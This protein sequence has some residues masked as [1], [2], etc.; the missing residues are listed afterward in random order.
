VARVAPPARDVYSVR[1]PAVATPPG[2]SGGT[3]ENAN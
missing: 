3:H 1:D 2:Y